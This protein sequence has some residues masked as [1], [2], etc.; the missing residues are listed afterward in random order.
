MSLNTNNIEE[1]REAYKKLNDEYNEY[2]IESDDICKEY[3]STIQILT[4][5]L[6]SLKSQNNNLLKENKTYKDNNNEL[7][8][9]LNKLKLKNK[10]KMNDIE[11]LNKKMDK[12]NNEYA[13]INE[14][15]TILK[16]KMVDLENDNEK[17]LEKIRQYEFEIEDLK[18]K[19][20]ETMEDLITT[21]TENNDVLKRNKLLLS[22]EKKENQLKKSDSN[23]LDDDI[24][25]F[26]INRA[27]T[28]V[29][30]NNFDS[31]IE[32]MRNRKNE[33]IKFKQSIQKEISHYFF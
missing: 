27:Y 33:I 4:D 22:N 23:P 2:K 19:L 21:Q 10:D 20:D 7:N 25:G 12:L 24:S 16:N 18:G 1:L 15:K 3:E 31:I 14:N 26:R 5:S 28:V 11:L 32:N 30:K 8:E 9:E 29:I 6:E 17:Y 13:K